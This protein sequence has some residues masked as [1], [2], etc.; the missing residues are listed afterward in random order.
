MEVSFEI[1]GL[2]KAEIYDPSWEDPQVLC[3]EK[4]A[5]VKGG[6]GPFGLLVMASSGLREQ[7]GVLFRVFKAPNKDVVLLCHD[8]TKYVYIIYVFL[9]Y[10]IYI[11]IHI[12]EHYLV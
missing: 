11:Y 12:Y 3:G 4:G 2:E 8:A 6:V 7:T 5:S 1:T 10:N 9:M